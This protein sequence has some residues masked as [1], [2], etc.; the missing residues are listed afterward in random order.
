LTTLAT[1]VLIFWR[2]KAVFGGFGRAV[3]RLP[4]TGDQ[5]YDVVMAGV[6]RFAAWQT[7]RVQ[8]GIQRRYILIV[9]AT[10]GLGLAV[11]LGIKDA[12]RW[13]TETPQATLLE[14]SL[15]LLVAASAV[16]TILA[17][18]RF[19]AICSLGV[20]GTC[21]ALIFLIFG[22]PD[23]AMTQLIVETL[24]TVLV[25]M[26]LLK[27]PDFSKEIWPSR[28]IRI[29]NGFVALTV[30]VSITLVL[31]AV[32]AQPPQRAVTEYF[33]RTAVPGG[34]G[35]NIVNVILVDFRALDTLGEITVLGIA[36]VAAFA[37]LMPG[38]R[39][40]LKASRPTKPSEKARQPD[41]TE[42]AA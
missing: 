39:R 31:L 35:R 15:A 33:E 29:R 21:T 42:G 23:V 38:P 37:L 2:R 26:V 20:V 19:L 16:V 28:A 36:G 22:A 4:L 6:S 5:A 11:T 10:L 9:F 14:W 27:L 3:S 32:T 40:R 34:H 30:G 1:A 8:S 7:R 13:P 18:T 12:I 25:A 24:V 17:R 41:A